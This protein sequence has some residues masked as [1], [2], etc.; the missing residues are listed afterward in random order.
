MDTEAE[1][2]ITRAVNEAANVGTERGDDDNGNTIGEIDGDREDEERSG[3]FSSR[4]E[5][6]HSVNTGGMFTGRRKPTRS[7]EESFDSDCD[8]FRVEF[9]R[10]KIDKS[11]IGGRTSCEE[12]KYCEGT[13]IPNIR[14]QGR[15]FDALTSRIIHSI[16]LRIDIR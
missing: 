9:T 4:S 1:E 3:V 13:E 2:D 16:A 14:G 11:K 10:S 8:G 15:D 6:L 5:L 7:V 12:E